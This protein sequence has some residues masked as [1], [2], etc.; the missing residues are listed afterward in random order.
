MASLVT[1]YSA[2]NALAAKADGNSANSCSS[3]LLLS[4]GWVVMFGVHRI[5]FKYFGKLA[6]V[7]FV[8]AIAALVFTL[9]FGTD[10]NDARRWIKLLS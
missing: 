10:I 2:I 6:N 7:L 8:L 1:V 4:G 9:F 3:K 5:H